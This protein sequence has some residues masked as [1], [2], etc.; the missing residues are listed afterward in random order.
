MTDNFHK[1]TD[2]C[3]VIIWL[4]LSQKQQKTNQHKNSATVAL[5]LTI[6]TFF[7]SKLCNVLNKIKHASHRMLLSVSAKYF[8]HLH[9][10][11]VPKRKKREKVKNMQSNGHARRQDQQTFKKC[12]RQSCIRLS[13]KDIGY[14]ANKM[15]YTFLNTKTSLSGRT[16]MLYTIY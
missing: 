16:M 8:F 1:Q 3:S 11:V 14:P 7:W 2:S 4:L 10:N 6:T 9:T 15:Q 13:G 5:N 12:L